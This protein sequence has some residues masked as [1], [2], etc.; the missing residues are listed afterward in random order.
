MDYDELLN[1]KIRLEQEIDKVKELIRREQNKLIEDGQRRFRNRTD[2]GNTGRSDATD[3][4]QSVD[5]DK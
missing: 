2:R 3:N 1:Y 4:R 5:S